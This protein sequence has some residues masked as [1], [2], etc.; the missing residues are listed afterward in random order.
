VYLVQ[1]SILNAFSAH[2]RQAAHYVQLI[3]EEIFVPFVIL[4]MSTQPVLTAISLTINK[5]TFANPAQMYMTNAYSALL[6]QLVLTA[7]LAI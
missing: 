1:L 2:H 7:Q 3:I 5:V 4:D 6:F